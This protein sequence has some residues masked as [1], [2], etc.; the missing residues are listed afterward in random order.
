[1]FIVKKT[2]L[3]F[4]SLSLFCLSP[5]TVSAACSYFDQYGV[6]NYL[7]VDFSYPTC[8]D[9]GYYK[10]EC[11][12]CHDVSY[13]YTDPLGHDYV[14]TNYVE[15]TC[16]TPGEI[17]VT[18]TICGSSLT[19]PTSVGYHD[20][21]PDYYVV[22]PTCQTQGERHYTC[23][24]CKAEMTL[25]EEYGD[26][27]YVDIG[28]VTPATC[29][30]GGYSARQCKICGQYEYVEIPQLSHQWFNTYSGV[31]STCTYNGY[32]VYE[33]SMCHTQRTETLPLSDHSYSAWAVTTP[34]T[35]HSAGV[36]RRTCFQCGTYEEDSFYPDGTLYRGCPSGQDVASIQAM[37]IDLSYLDDVADGIFGMLTAE[38]VRKYQAHAGF[39][40]DGIAW[41][42]TIK[43]LTDEYNQKHAP[44][45]ASIQPSGAS[46]APSGS[47]HT[48]FPEEAPAAVTDIQG[49]PKGEASAESIATA[50]STPSVPKPSSQDAGQAATADKGGNSSSKLPSSW[51][52]SGIT[53]SS[54]ASSG[55]SSGFQPEPYT[56]GSKPKPLEPEATPQPQSGSQ[57]R[58]PAISATTIPS[59][60]PSPSPAAIAVPSV[61]AP[62]PSGLILTEDSLAITASVLMFSPLAIA[63][64][65]LIAA[66]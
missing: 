56:Q 34:A 19:V 1:M 30:V 58:R 7:Q 37:L 18:C 3:A 64:L 46:T 44:A 23:S 8:T 36:R 2:S 6:H 53:S 28:V 47:P 22:L 33:C 16:T 27:Q 10:L 45:P 26:H 5:L 35:D 66:L 25:P 65:F 61:T 15:P 40:E 29:Q 13:E 48:G 39:Y 17:T 9:Y 52:P 60:T 51:N 49:P 11:Q 31:A 14:Q 57:M 62:A 21:Q 20:W 12:T 59:P 54:T 43:A 24:V 4:L 38:S 50:S 42:Q 55:A 32:A 41:P 63:E